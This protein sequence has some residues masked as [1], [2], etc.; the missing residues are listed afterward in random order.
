MLQGDHGPVAYRNI[1]IRPLVPPAAAG[2]DALTSS[3]LKWTAQSPIFSAADRDGDHYFS[4]KDPS[5]VR[6][7]DRWHMFTTMRGVKRTHQI[8]YASFSDWSEA[9]QAKRETM[10]LT[11]GYF[12]APQ[13]FYFRPHKKWYLIYQIL[14]KSRTPVPQPAFSTTSDIANVAS[15]TKPQ[16]L[17]DDPANG[18]KSWIDFWTICDETKC[19]MFFATLDGRLWRSE[20][21]IGSFPKGWTR[22]VVVITDDIYEASHT[23]RLKGSKKY[24]TFVEARRDGGQRYFKSYVADRLDG[25]W[26]P[27]AATFEHAFTSP[28]NVSFSGERWTDSFSHGELIRDGNDERLIVDE[29]RPRL[30]IQG[31]RDQDSAGKKYGEVPWRLGLLDGVKR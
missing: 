29:A 30:L 4:I 8:E 1:V 10:Q 9:P 20:T 3:D 24:V 31:V 6:A 11:D 5:I 25:Q 17:M 18:V 19:H 12:C 2:R 28:P 13:V 21:A 22:P 7:G 26:Q 23:Y 16:L 15:W 14:D 27:L